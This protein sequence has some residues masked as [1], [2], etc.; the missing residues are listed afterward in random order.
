MI[1]LHISHYK[2]ISVTVVTLEIGLKTAADLTARWRHLMIELLKESKENSFFL[3][4]LQSNLHFAIFC[5]FF[6]N[7]SDT[8]TISVH[9]ALNCRIINKQ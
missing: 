9:I 3:I 1:T 8:G 4:N 7:A 6:Y 2:T 5:I